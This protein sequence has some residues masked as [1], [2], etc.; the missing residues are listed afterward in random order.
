[1]KKILNIYICALLLPAVF[2]CSNDEKGAV[3]SYF[4]YKGSDT[5]FAVNIDETRQYYNPILPGCYPDPSIC[6]KGN[7]YYLATSSFAYYPGIP[8]FH[9]NDLVNWVQIGHVLNRPSQLKLDSI[10]LSGGVY[11]PA[12]SYNPHND[13]FYLINTCVDG[14]GNF[15][16]K[17][18]DPKENNWS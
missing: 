15:I 9:S 5:V 11:A 4:E 1:M 16:V 7:D 10:R 6:R 2:A 3:F 18:K 12:I 17:T 8:I 13:M 14:I